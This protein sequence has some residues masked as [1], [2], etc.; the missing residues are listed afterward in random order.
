M[1]PKRKPFDIISDI[2]NSATMGKELASK[3]IL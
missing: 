3:P 2:F 1:K